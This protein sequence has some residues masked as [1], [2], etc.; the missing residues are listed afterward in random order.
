MIKRLLLI[1]VICLPLAGLAQDWETA[2]VSDIFDSVLQDP[3]GLASDTDPE[4]ELDEVLAIN[5]S[6][7][8][9][10]AAK[11]LGLSLLDTVPLPGLG[12]SLARLRLPNILNPGKLLAALIKA[13]PGG[14][15]G[16]NAVYRLSGSPASQGAACEGLRCYGQQLVGWPPLGCPV[17]VAI[18]LLDSAIDNQNPALQG[19]SL[20]SLRLSPT[21][22]SPRESAHGTAVAAQLIG[23]AAAGFA[24][25]LPEATLYAA[26][27]FSLDAQ[28][29]PFT[30]ALQLAQGLDW[31]ARQPLKTINISLSGPDSP[32]LHKAVQALVAKGVAIA[33][34][35]GNAGPKAP[36]QY[37][38]AYAEVLAV[39]AVD[40]QLQPYA[41]ASPGGYVRLAAPG[42]GIWTASSGG[43]GEFRDGT[44]FATPYVTAA[45]ALGSL[46]AALPPPAQRIATLANRSRDLGAKGVDPVYGVGLLQVAGCP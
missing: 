10:A 35:S 24:G 13:D 42:V 40:R 6:A 2:G 4:F 41:R 26:D 11:L 7:T 33:A 3:S 20:H 28:G 17:K 32:V 8:G 22:V 14:E 29:Q 37:P 34:A 39:T 1:A 30:N 15:Y 45:L 46:K 25:L 5:L 43:A 36:P 18:G 23:N 38:A 12:F 27:V 31:L 9:L 44:S 21:P 19:R 16:A